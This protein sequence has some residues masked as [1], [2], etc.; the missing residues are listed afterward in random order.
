[1]LAGE[2]AM[3]DAR[4]RLTAVHWAAAEWLRQASSF[5]P[6]AEVEPPQY[7][8]KEGPAQL[9]RS[10]GHH[11]D[12]HRPQWL[13]RDPAFASGR[14]DC[15]RSG[16]IRRIGRAGAGSASMRGYHKAT[17]THGAGQGSAWCEAR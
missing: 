3:A 10:S 4:S 7:S 16:L 9:G 8:G 13:A 17:G 5:E 2:G 1:M 14:R 11:A 12:T 15:G 6:F